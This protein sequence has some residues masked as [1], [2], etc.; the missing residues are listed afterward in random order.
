M[1]YWKIIYGIRL[2]LEG[3]VIYIFYI[4]YYEDINNVFFLLDLL[5][6]NKISIFVFLVNIF[7]FFS[8]IFLGI[9][10]VVV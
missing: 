2:Y 6:E 3:G 5:L 8:I 1:F 9:V 10:F 7:R 4:F